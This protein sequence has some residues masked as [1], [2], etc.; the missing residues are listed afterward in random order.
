MNVTPEML[1]FLAGKMGLDRPYS[2]S[3]S[4]MYF[5][6]W[7]HA[8]NPHKSAAQFGRLVV[9]AA[10]KELTMEFDNTVVTA[11]SEIHQRRIQIDCDS[12]PDSIR[13]A[14]VVAV[15]RALNYEEADNVPQP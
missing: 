6:G 3:G 7:R 10:Q 2:H 14:A 15:C 13:A 12:T 4:V 5:D 9:W 8:F 11:W 1:L